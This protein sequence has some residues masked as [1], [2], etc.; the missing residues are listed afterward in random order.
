LGAQTVAQT[1]SEGEK[2]AG[3]TEKVGDSNSES[4]KGSLE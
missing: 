2:D 1:T 4:S 3:K